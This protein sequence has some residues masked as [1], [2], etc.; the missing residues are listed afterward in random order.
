MTGESIFYISFFTC[1]LSLCPSSTP[2]PEQLHI[3][4]KTASTAKLSEAGRRQ[5][6]RRK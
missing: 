2:I 4:K 5:A 1:P 3:K 6:G